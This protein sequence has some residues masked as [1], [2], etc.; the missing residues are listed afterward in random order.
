MTPVETDN[1]TQQPFDQFSKQFF[2]ELFKPLK[3]GVK[4]N[5][6]VHAERRYVDVY[7]LPSKKAPKKDFKALGLLGRMVS[8]TCLLEPF[9]SPLQKDDIKN[10]FLKLL[11]VHSVAE[12]GNNAQPKAEKQKTAQ[13]PTKSLTQLPYLWIFATSV[14]NAV[15]NSCCA[16]PNLADWGEGVYGLPEICHTGD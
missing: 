5:Y 7:W 6:E 15:L 11:M 1:I 14:S 13:Q 2:N 8:S 16:Q 4:I 9:R 3:G 10:C 12:K